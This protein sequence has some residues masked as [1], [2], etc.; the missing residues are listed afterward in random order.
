M[1]VSCETLSRDERRAAKNLGEA[2]V[3]ATPRKTRDDLSLLTKRFRNALK[4]SVAGII[5]AGKV[6]IEA[7]ERIEHGR[8]TD[9]VDRELRFGAP[10]QTGGREA[11]IRKGQMLMDLGTT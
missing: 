4:Q 8:F 9:W 10:T 7:K 3:S 11:N 1:F 2:N 6:L 5:E